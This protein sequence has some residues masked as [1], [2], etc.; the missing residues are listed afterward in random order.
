MSQKA[1]RVCK[2]CCERKPLDKENFQQAKSK[3]NRKGIAKQYYYWTC[4][5]CQ[6]IDRMSDYD[7]CKEVG[8]KEKK[9][10]CIDEP[11]FTGYKG[12]YLGHWEIDR[13]LKMGYL[14]PGSIWEFCG[15]RY[16]VRGNEGLNYDDPPEKFKRQRME[17]M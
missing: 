10:Q 15:I 4:L 6:N 1:T 8:H 9:Y 3:P 11:E 13:T 16:V 2:V 14:P 12:K 17:Q 5:E 7:Y